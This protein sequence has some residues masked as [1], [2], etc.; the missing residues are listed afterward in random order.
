MTPGQTSDALRVKLRQIGSRLTDEQITSAWSQTEKAR[1]NFSTAA[2]A[3]GVMLLAKK[4]SLGHGK[5]IP[6]CEKFGGKL[7]DAMKGQIGNALPIW[8]EVTPRTLRN[9]SFLGEHFLSDLEQGA[10]AGEIQDHK[11]TIEGVTA[12]DVLALDS[13]P[14]KARKSVITRIE[15]FVAGRSLRTMLL[16]LRRSENAGDAEHAAHEA[17]LAKKK[18]GKGKEGA[19]TGTGTGGTG[20]PAGQLEFKEMM[21]PIGAIDT[22]FETP[23]FVEKTDKGFWNAIAD[24]LQTQADRARKL[25]EGIK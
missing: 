6:W 18:A 25:A 11:P 7:A 5:W 20:A 23:S 12:D 22:L 15:Q 13:L 17:E 9:Y 4:E 2:T 16:D 10:F 14:A 3:L 24:K 1:V 8:K 19:A 21:A